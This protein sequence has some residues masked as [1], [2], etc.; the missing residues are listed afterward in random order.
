MAGLAEAVGAAVGQPASVRIGTVQSV[1]PPVVTAQGVAFD[2]VGFLGGYGP[3]VGD[4]VALLGQSSASGSDPTS[5][6]ALGKVV[7]TGGVPGGPVQAGVEDVE[8]VA[9]TSAVQGVVFA[10]PYATEPT[11]TTNIPSGAGATANWHSRA[12][13]VT[14]TGFEVFIFGPSSSFVVPVHWQAIPRTQ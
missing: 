3:A 9:T 13:N 1:N 8:V 5:W 10:V 2:D 11:V 14:T 7:S 12:I 6:L 4:T